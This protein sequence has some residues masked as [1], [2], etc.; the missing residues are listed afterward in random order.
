MALQWRNAP[1]SHLSLRTRLLIAGTAWLLLI[2]FLVIG[3]STAVP[4]WLHT[5]GWLFVA[6]SNIVLATYW[7]RRWNARR[8]RT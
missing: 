3:V 8:N 5:L 2:S 1:G 6:V 4:P 7:V